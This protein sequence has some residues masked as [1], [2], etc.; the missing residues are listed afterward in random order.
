MASNNQGT[1][2]IKILEMLRNETDE[3]HVLTRKDIEARLEE[4][5][6]EFER[7]TFYKDIELL[8][9]AGFVI[10]HSTVGH[11]Y[12]Y[13]LVQQDFSVAELKLIVDALHAANFLTEN[14]TDDLIDKVALVGGKFKAEDIKSNNIHFN[15]KKH[16]NE[17]I[18]F[19]IEQ[20]NN[21]IKDKKK[22]SCKVFDLNYKGN[23]VYRHNKKTYTLEPI[24]LIHYDDNYYVLCYDDERGVYPR[25]IDRLMLR[26]KWMVDHSNW[27]IAV[28][29]GSAGGT[30]NTIEY[31][32]KEGIEI[33]IIDC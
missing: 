9:N 17:Q 28:Y 24:A 20:L 1:R 7:R 27:L 15:T 12:G 23:I 2:I 21:A 5:G 10:E 4:Q 11:A 31:A 29:N 26:N 25:R 30:K 14:K 8:T 18:L 16:S 13:Y 33:H 32:K 6:I 22:I 3:S 19:V